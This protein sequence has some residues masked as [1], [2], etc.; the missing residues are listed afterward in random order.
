MQYNYF[1]FRHFTL[2]RSLSLWL[3]FCPK[4]KALQLFIYV[5]KWKRERK[6]KL[7]V[8]QIKYFSTWKSTIDDASR[9]FIE[10]MPIFRFHEFPFLCRDSL[11]LLPCNSLV[12]QSCLVTS[13]VTFSSGSK[14]FHLFIH[15]KYRYNGKLLLKCFP[16]VDWDSNKTRQDTLTKDWPASEKMFLL[17]W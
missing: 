7:N 12:Y 1:L 9:P 17:T 11:T 14:P 3:F 10:R 13:H 15:W 6:K 16:S 8:L 4:E 5:V 2:F